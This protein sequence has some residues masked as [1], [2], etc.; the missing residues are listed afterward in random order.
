MKSSIFL[1]QVVLSSHLQRYLFIIVICLVTAYLGSAQTIDGEIA[2]SSSRDGNPEIYK[3][4]A[5]ATNLVRLTRHPAIDTHP[6]WSPDGE[7]LVF[8]SNRRNGSTWE[9]YVMNAD[10]KKLVQLTTNNQP[11]PAYDESPSWSPDGGK[12]VFASNREGNGEIYVMDANGKNI[13]RLTRTIVTEATPSWSPDGAKIAFT[14]G[15]ESAESDIFV[16]D[17]NGANPVN[18]TRNPKARNEN[19]SWSPDGDQIVFQSWRE[20]NWDIFVINA[21]GQHLIRLTHHFAWDAFAAWSP[22]GQKIAF[23]SLRNLRGE[24]IFLMNSD[25]TNLI[26]LTQALQQRIERSAS[27]RPA[28]FPVSLRD[29]FSVTWGTVKQ[30]LY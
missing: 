18:L 16:M 25:G 21:D 8:T 24:E 20:K 26:Q 17:V 30:K 4:N 7:K 14:S 1:K 28:P 6:V 2:F 12:I 19:P 29:K 5:D 11:V 15:N 3:M 22:D 27:W 13:M 10:G 23:T 9:I